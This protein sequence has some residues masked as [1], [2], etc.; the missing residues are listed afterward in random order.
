MKKI[1]F[2]LFL[3]ISFS[4]QAQYSSSGRQRQKQ[5]Q[6]DFTP[7]KIPKPNFKIKKYLG[8]IE[9]DIKKAAKKSSIKISSEK[10]KQF[11]KSLTVYNKKIKDITRINSFLLSSTKEM[12]EVFQK[13]AR[14]TRD[15]SDQQKVQKKMNEDLKALT[16]TIKEEDLKLV[17][18]F[19]ELLSKKQ[20]KKWINYNKKLYKTFPKE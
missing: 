15:Y 10:G 13:K 18:S 8:I 2:L 5:Q 14:K 1:I 3:Y 20:Y 12:V 16:E 17:K 4:T 9:Y 11:S 7:Q 6:R 19:K